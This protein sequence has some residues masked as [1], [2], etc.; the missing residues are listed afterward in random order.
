MVMI[1]VMMTTMIMM[2]TINTLVGVPMMI[3]Q[4][5]KINNDLQIRKKDAMS[6]K[7]ITAFLMLD[8]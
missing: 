8:S 4:R 1:M 5:R 2:I 3:R 7:Y 6:W